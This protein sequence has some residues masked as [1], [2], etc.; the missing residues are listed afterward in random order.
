MLGQHLILPKHD[1]VVISRRISSQEKSTLN[2]ESMKTLDLEDY[3][4]S[5]YD[6]GLGILY[7]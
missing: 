1:A 3:L 2:L 7:Y 5:S 6:S 4:A